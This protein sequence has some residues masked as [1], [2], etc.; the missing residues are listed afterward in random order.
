MKLV[1]GQY[2]MLFENGGVRIVKAGK[3]LYFNAR[4]VYGEPSGGGLCPGLSCSFKE[5]VACVPVSENEWC[6][7]DK[8][9]KILFQT[10]EYKLQ[11]NTFSEGKI[12]VYKKTPNGNVYS[13]LDK[14]GN[15]ISKY[16]FEKARKRK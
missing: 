6:V 11:T 5:D 12:C 13:F 9:G 4:P 14:K 2:E 3:E 1:N 15:Q 7:Y 10:K 8:A 16:T